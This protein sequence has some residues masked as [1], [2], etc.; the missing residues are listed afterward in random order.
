VNNAIKVI[1]SENKMIKL[2]NEIATLVYNSFDK[3]PA[4]EKWSSESR[5][6]SAVNGMLFYLG[7]AAGSVIPTETRYELIHARKEVFALRTVCNFAIERKFIDLDNIA[8]TKFEELVTFIDKEIK[9]AEVGSEKEEAIELKK[10]ERKYS[11]YE[12]SRK[13]RQ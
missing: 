6:R 11:Q 9:K 2:A 7:H 8:M 4:P 12:K 13:L 3:L 1:G 5:M 10:W